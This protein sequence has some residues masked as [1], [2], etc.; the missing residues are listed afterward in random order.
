MA[1]A[2]LAA[3]EAT[4]QRLAVDPG[5]SANRDVHG[6]RLQAR[7]R[8][9]RSTAGGVRSILAT[10]AATAPS[11]DATEL[12]NGRRRPSYGDSDAPRCSSRTD[13]STARRSLISFASLTDGGHRGH[14]RQRLTQVHDAGS[15]H[16]PRLTIT[17]SF[18]LSKHDKTSALVRRKRPTDDRARVSDRRSN[19]FCDLRM[20]VATRIFSDK[21]VE[22]ARYTLGGSRLDGRWRLG[23]QPVISTDDTASTRTGDNASKHTNQLKDKRGY[24]DMGWGTSHNNI[25][26]DPFIELSM[27]HSVK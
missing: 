3:A 8:R 15:E 10:T 1:T 14:R 18:N 13:A 5:I 4:S 25:L 11:S 19:K 23:G 6:R 2:A 27:L 22:L 20:S 16:A 9:R 7:R 12:Q 21:D 26:N 24:L 17:S